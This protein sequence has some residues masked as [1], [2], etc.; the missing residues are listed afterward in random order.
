MLNASSSA[1]T[2]KLRCPSYNE[3]YLPGLS[4]RLAR[5]YHK[6]S[7]LI[8][9]SALQSCLLPPAL[10]TKVGDA[11]RPSTILRWKRLFWSDCRHIRARLRWAGSYSSPR[12]ILPSTALP[13]CL[14]IRILYWTAGLFHESIWNQIVPL[15]LWEWFSRHSSHR[16]SETWLAGKKF[17]TNTNWRTFTIRMELAFLYAGSLYIIDWCFLNSEY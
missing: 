9:S 12:S 16:T 3:S 1:E 17:L 7:F 5:N 8:H 6:A 14:L 13:R 10:Q 4:L 11:I 2:N 15:I